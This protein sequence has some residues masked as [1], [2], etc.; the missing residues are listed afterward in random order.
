MFLD[1]AKIASLL[2]QISIFILELYN[3]IPMK[4]VM[5]NNLLIFFNNHKINEI[6]K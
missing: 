5:K 1:K 3:Q 6:I 4:Y 2:Y